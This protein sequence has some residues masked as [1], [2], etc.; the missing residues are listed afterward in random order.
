[1]QTDKFIETS[2]RSSKSHRRSDL[3]CVLSVCL[4]PTLPF[5]QVHG[6]IRVMVR[7]RARE[8]WYLR[9]PQLTRLAQQLGEPLVPFQ[10]SFGARTW[11]EG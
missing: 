7:V 6:Q 3:W 1:M 2:E 11:D 4:S 9:K 8:V 5:N 10:T